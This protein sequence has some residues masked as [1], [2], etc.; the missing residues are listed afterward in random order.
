M[1]YREGFRDGW[2]AC[3]ETYATDQREGAGTE[4]EYVQWSQRPRTGSDRAGK[5]KKRKPSAW[6]QFVKVNSKKPRFIYQSGA[7]KGKLNLKKMGVA[8]RR[9]PAG[10]KAKGR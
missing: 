7:K 4:G 3:A 8:W 1:T 6:N 10:R 2:R 9:T 5:G